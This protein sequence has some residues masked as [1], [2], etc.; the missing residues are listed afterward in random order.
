VTRKI[1]SSLAKI[2]LG[3]IENFS[4]GDVSSERDWGYAGDYVEAI[5]KMMQREYPSE[6]VIATGKTHTVRDFLIEAIKV[7]GLPSDYSNYVKFDTSLIRPLADRNLV[8]D[9]SKAQEELS[10]R[11]KVDF[12]ELVKIMVLNDIAIE[13]S[14]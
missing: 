9:S 5:W 7:A 3:K 10:W 13:N 1:T 8:G 11:P 4:L 6:Y 14:I 12:D 2:K